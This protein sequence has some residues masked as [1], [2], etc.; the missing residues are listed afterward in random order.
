MVTSQA[1]D[2]PIASE[3]TLKDVDKQIIQIH[4]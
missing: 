2:C 3:L 1:L 4:E